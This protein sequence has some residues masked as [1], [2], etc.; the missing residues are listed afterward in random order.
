[1]LG[2]ERKGLGN[3]NALATGGVRWWESVRAAEGSA[4]AGRA[5]RIH[6][7]QL[8]NTLAPRLKNV[9]PHPLPADK[10]VEVEDAD[11]RARARRS[12]SSQGP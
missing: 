12:A 5:G 10:L 4:P 7:G 2:P 1:M 3:L 6:R 8:S 11:R 9:S